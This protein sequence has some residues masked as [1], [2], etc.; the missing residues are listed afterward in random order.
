FDQLER[1]LMEQLGTERDLSRMD[2]ERSYPLFRCRFWTARNTSVNCRIGASITPLIEPLVIAAALGTPLALKNNGRFEGELIR[3]IDPRLAA[4]PS[5]YG[6]AF[7]APPPL[8]VRARYALTSLR[9]TWLRR[10]AFRVRHRLLPRVPDAFE[11][12]RSPIVEQGGL[13]RRDR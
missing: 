5:A 9:P 13:V 2:I 12:E 10:Y 4:Y 3:R 1:K 8:S 7:D 6:F 11:Q